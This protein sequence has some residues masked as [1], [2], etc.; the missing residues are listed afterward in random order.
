M[1]QHP[2]FTYL[3]ESVG[4][5]DAVGRPPTHTSPIRSTAVCCRPQANLRVRRAVR[6]STWLVG[7]QSN[8]G[9]ANRMRPVLNYGPS[10]FLCAACLLLPVPGT[11]GL[12]PL[13]T[14]YAYPTSPAYPSLPISPCSASCAGGAA[15]AVLKRAAP[16]PSP[17]SPSRTLR[18]PP[19][20]VPVQGF[21]GL[22]SPCLTLILARGKFIGGS[23]PE[24]SVSDLYLCTPKSQNSLWVLRLAPGKYYLNPNQEQR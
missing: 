16:G 24:V 18:F 22:P 3:P 15:C 20:P 1:R 8:V 21:S 14:R 11:L 9:S 13:R 5:R 23:G 12:Y 17:S 7:M 2:S 10:Y 4:I 6:T 19:P